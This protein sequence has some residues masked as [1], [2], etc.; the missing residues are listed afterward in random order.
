[1]TGLEQLL[2]KLRQG[3]AN[4]PH[5]VAL[6]EVTPLEHRQ[7]YEAAPQS[8]EGVFIP[9][10]FVNWQQHTVRFRGIPVRVGVEQV[11][12]ADHPKTFKAMHG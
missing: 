4:S 8:R 12:W 9:Y 2:Y 11:E 3:L 7:L 10:E 5:Q 1:M 6:I